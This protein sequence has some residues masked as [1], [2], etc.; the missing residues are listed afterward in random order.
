MS[1]L[2]QQWKLDKEHWGPDEDSGWPERIK[3]H[4]KDFMVRA[5]NS[6]NH[7]DNRYMQSWLDNR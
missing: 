1:L 7:K 4:A 3:D 6:A 5:L 2:L